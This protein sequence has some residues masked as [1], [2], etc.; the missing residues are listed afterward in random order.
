M[1][2]Y[3]QLLHILYRKETHP[4]TLKELFQA[5]KLF[6][7]TEGS[8]TKRFVDELLHDLAIDKSKC[9]F[10]DIYDFFEADVIFTFTDLLTREELRD[11]S[12]Y[13]LFSLDDVAN[14]GSGS[15][16]E[17]ICTRHPQFE[18]FIISKELYGSFT[19][20]AILTVKVDAILVCRTDLDA[21]VVHRVIQTLSNYNQDLKN[22]NPLLYRFTAEFDPHKLS[23]TIHPGTRQYLERNEPTFF[24]RYA[25][26]I[27][28]VVTI[29]IAFASAAFSLTQWQQQRKKNKID[30]YYHKLLLLR[31]KVKEANGP[32]ELGALTTELHSIQEETIGLVTREKLLANDSYLI[33]LK[34][35][36]IVDDEIER[37]RLRMSGR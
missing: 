1:P 22:I 7:G 25:E 8:G 29:L 34:L 20:H 33:F 6:A 27:G 32:D 12:G 15:L 4:R 26:S 17:S 37:N 35:S 23:Y 14:L 9:T 2:L 3:P 5:G 36:R 28:V 24:E 19:E 30:V 13:H 16:A 11:L 18:P 10:V 31:A 21:G